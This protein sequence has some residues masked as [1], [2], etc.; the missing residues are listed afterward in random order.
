METRDRDSSS[1]AKAVPDRWTVGGLTLHARV[2][3]RN[4]G[5]RPPV[6]LVH[7]LGMSSR[8]M[9]PTLRWMG[10][11]F[12]VYAPDQPGFGLSAKPSRPLDILEL[13]EWVVRWMDAAGL[14]RAALVANS[15]GCQIAVHA[16]V[17]HPDRVW[18]LVLQ[19]P[20]TDPQ[21]RSLGRQMRLLWRNRRAEPSP[22]MAPLIDYMHAGL[23]R[24][25]A[26]AR[27]MLADRIEDLLPRVAAPALVVRGADDP[28][29]PHRWA[30]E[31]AA[32][33][34]DGQLCEVPGAAHTMI[35]VAARDLARVSRSFLWQAWERQA[36]RGAMASGAS[37]RPPGPGA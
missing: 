21:A 34:P 18:A 32:L 33:L 20:T 35:A 22:G 28:L 11:D 2:A 31:V 6:V 30:A 7:G 27:Y 15:L 26:T 8:Y 24:T 19:G 23:R 14:A 4:T 29:V 13:A 25:V 1:L 10:R 3:D 36:G 12:D 37:S 16:A 17:R 5:Q 9:V